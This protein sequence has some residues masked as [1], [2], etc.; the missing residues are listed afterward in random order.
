M[1]RKLLPFLALGAAALT[2][3]TAWN[4]RRLRRPQP[5]QTNIQEKV[6][7]LIP[8]RDEEQHIGQTLASVCEQDLLADLQVHVLDDGSHDATAIIARSQADKDARVHVYEEP[9]EDPPAGWLGKNYACERLSER[10]DADVL[11]F[12]DADVRLE[13]LAIASL[14]HE[15]RTGGFDLIAPYPR[16]EASGFLER[17]VQP[18]LVWSWA[19]TVPLAVAEQ[20]QWASMSVA[21]GQL[22]V[23]DARAYRKI[24]GH[25]S[26]S[27]D[28]IE[29]VA[30]MRQVR[31]AGLRAVTVDGSQL[32]TCR[33]YESSADL[34]DGYTK[35]AWRAF[36]GPV[37]SVVVNTALIGL[38]VIP[39]VAAVTGRGSTRAWGTAGYLAGCTARVLVARRT[40]ERVWPD[41]FAHP[42]SIAVFAFINALSWWRRATGTT[43]WKGRSI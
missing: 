4:L 11:V 36:G 38:Y 43:S 33:M 30:L 37:G 29:D 35:S 41:A 12:V 13:P 40:G 16:Q 18:L 24:G 20:R 9:D 17:L 32:A 19:T 28:V 27:G 25:A 5:P 10:T 15:L 1:V 23:F 21:N 39:A 7:V 2:V 14:V 22:M 34:I 6:A 3:H 31:D 8:A 26:V 42:A